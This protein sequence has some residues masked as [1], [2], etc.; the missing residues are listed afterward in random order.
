MARAG[1]DLNAFLFEYTRKLSIL[2][3]TVYNA[4][5]ERQ[6]YDVLG[7]LKQ[8]LYNFGVDGDGKVLPPYPK[9]YR[10]FKQQAGVRSRPTTL[11][12]TGDWYKSL[13]VHVDTGKNRHVVEVRSVGEDKKTKGLKRKYGAAILTLTREEQEGVIKNLEEILAKEFFVDGFEIVIS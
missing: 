1:R 5:R 10:L 12:L 11:F 6:G 4:I 7:K 3:D 2:D 8:R 13:M 9:E